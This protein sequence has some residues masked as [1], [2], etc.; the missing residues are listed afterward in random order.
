[1]DACTDFSVIMVSPEIQPDN[2]NITYQAG[3][4]TIEKADLIIEV[5]SSFITEGDLTPTNFSIVTTGLVCEDEPPVISNFVVTDE[6]GTI[7]TGN[8]AGGSYNVNADLSTLTGYDNYNITQTAGILFVNPVVG[9]NDRIKASGICQSPATL[10]GQPEITTRLQFEYTNG[11]D[12]PIFIPNGPKNIL[13]GN[14]FFVGSPPELFLPGTHTYDIYTNGGRL[15]WEVKTQGCTSASKSANGSN[16]DPC[17]VDT[18]TSRV[19]NTTVPS[20]NMNIIEADINLNTVPLITDIT[21]ETRI[22]PNPAGDIINLLVAE[23]TGLA[24]LII[25]DHTG[26][27]LFKREY[28]LDASS[29]F[30]IDI[31]EFNP[32]ILL[33]SYEHNGKRSVFIIVKK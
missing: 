6:G 17:N 3:S 4:L 27:A 16:A 12:V 32:G 13:K 20:S 31:S 33:F 11:L 19:D 24:R 1:S 5:S 26:R 23:R 2:Y 21:E 28:E 10:A 9:C 18:T 30:Q 25:F 8:L 7:Q 15:Q 29:N 22:F 14:A